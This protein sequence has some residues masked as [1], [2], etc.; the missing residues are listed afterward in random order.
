MSE[1]ELGL[2]MAIIACIGGGWSAHY[3]DQP[4]WKG[5]LIIAA[6]FVASAAL[7][8][9]IGSS[10]AILNLVIAVV[11]AGAL[12]SFLRMTARQTSTILLG[13]MLILV[14]AFIAVDFFTRA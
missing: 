4:F 2:L 1:N 9:L 14:P 11:V 13:A 8:S 12:G 5:V 7:L 3:L 10:S 6:S